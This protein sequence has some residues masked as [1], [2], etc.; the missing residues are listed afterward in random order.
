[1]AAFDCS[2]LSAI[3]SARSHD[4]V[5]LFNNSLSVDYLLSIERNLNGMKTTPSGLARARIS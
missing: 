2:L 1:M 5:F 3:L 4:G